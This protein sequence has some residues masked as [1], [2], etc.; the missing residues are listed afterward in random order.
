MRAPTVRP[1]GKNRFRRGGEFSR[2]SAAG[3]PLAA[4]WAAAV[5]DR[6]QAIDIRRG[7]PAQ[8]AP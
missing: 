8:A 6:P 2:R 4:G 1:A 5:D 3:W 7:T